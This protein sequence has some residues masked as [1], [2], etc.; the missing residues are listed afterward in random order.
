MKYIVILLIILTTFPYSSAKANNLP[1]RDL[2]GISDYDE[3]NIYGTNP[4]NRDT[5]GDSFSDWEEL[6]N[7][8]S[9]HNPLP[10][11]LV[12]NDNDGDGLNDDMEL[13]FK[14]SLINKDSDGDGYLDGDEVANGYDPLNKEKVKLTKRI[15]IDLNNQELGYFLGDVRLGKFIISSGKNNSTPTGTFTIKNKSPKAWS[16]YGLW[17]PFWMGMDSGKYGLH[18]LPIWPNGYREGED[19][20][21]TPVSHGCIRLGTSSSEFLYNWTPIDTKVIIY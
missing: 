9:P 19:H 10:I 8:F 20:L 3:I 4:D 13:R 17:M 18:E 12:D 2:D 16:P 15:E 6:N 21:G 14:T 1:D 5:D 11:K 7:G